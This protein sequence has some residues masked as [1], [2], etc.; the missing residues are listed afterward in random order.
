MK[1]EVEGMTQIRYQLVMR[2]RNCQLCG[3]NRATDLHHIINRGRIPNAELQT[4]LP[5]HFYAMLCRPCNLNDSV[6]T[7]DSDEGRRTLIQHNARKL[8][9][10]QGMRDALDHWHS[11]CRQ[12]NVSFSIDYDNIQGWLNELA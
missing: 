4:Q 9:G 7:A 6:I 2:Q 1:Q 12:Y 10:V 11:L 8:Y 5:I 3:K